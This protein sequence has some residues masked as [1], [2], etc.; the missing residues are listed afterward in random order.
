MEKKMNKAQKRLEPLKFNFGNDD[1]HLLNKQTQL[2]IVSYVAVLA[3]VGLTTIENSDWEQLVK[4]A[5][6]LKAMSGGTH[7]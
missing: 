4:A 1:D 2:Q 3:Q 7:K 5:P 6:V